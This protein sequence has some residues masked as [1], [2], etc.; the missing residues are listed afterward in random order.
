MSFLDYISWISL[1]KRKMVFLL[2]DHWKTHDKF[3][4]NPDVSPVTLS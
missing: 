4:Q 1:K 3:E 2:N